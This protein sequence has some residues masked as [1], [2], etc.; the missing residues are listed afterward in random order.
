MNCLKAL[1]VE[2]HQAFAMVKWKTRDNAEHQC[3]GIIR[4]MQDLANQSRGLL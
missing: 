3:N 1:G 2:D 4:K